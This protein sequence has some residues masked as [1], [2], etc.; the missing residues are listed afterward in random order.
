MRK[1]DLNDLYNNS[2]TN[3]KHEDHSGMG[4]KR[5]LSIFCNSL[6]TSKILQSCTFNFEENRSTPRHGVD[7]CSY[8]LKSLQIGLNVTKR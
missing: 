1:I 2:H 8:E 4:N 6:K 7:H 5:K 3:R